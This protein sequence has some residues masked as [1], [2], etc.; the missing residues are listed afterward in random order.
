MRA[1]RP[2]AES[3]R[4]VALLSDVR[5]PGAGAA[6]P[7]NV[8]DESSRDQRLQELHEDLD[9]ILDRLQHML[10]SNFAEDSK[11]PSPLRNH[12]VVAYLSNLEFP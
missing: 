6:Q 10:A 5:E 11:S 9:G 4:V 12:G 1:G 7:P 2:Q 8:G 3:N